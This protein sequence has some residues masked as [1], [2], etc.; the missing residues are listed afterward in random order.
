MA[1]KYSNLRDVNNR[2]QLAEAI[3]LKGPLT[4][5]VEA[6]NICNFRCSFCPE[7]LSNFMEE[8]GGRHTINITDF[9]KILS[10]ISAFKTVKTVNFYMMGEPFINKNIESLVKR[11]SEL[12]IADK[13]ILTTNGSAVSKNRYRKICESG[14]HYLRVSIY[15]FDQAS[16]FKTTGSKVP[17]ERIRNNIVG[18]KKY[19]DNN[20]FNFPHIYVKMVDSHSEDDNCSFLQYFEGIGDEIAIEPLMNWNDPDE[21]LDLDLSA[22]ELLSTDYFK[23]KKEVCPFPFYT[24]VIHSD[25]K[26]S[27]CC[28]DWNKKTCVGDLKKNTLEEIWTGDKLRN[29]QLSHIRRKK[30][31]IEGCKNCTFLHTSIDHIDCL[32]EVNFLTKLN[33]LG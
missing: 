11:A 4:I 10:Q 21:G 14:L 31:E 33:H 20:G 26:V 24:M 23:E 16:H 9:E 17:L 2:I 3:P 12:K 6:T 5:H 15:G 19:R 30:N 13:L 29:L 1:I 7:S 27:A 28:V 8:Q 25:L 18:L 22:N 32:N